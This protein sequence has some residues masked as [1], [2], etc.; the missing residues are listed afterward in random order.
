MFGTVRDM[1]RMRSTPKIR[2][3]P[4]PGTPTIMS[5]I[6]SSGMEPAGTPAAPIAVMIDIITNNEL[7]AQGEMHAENLGEEQDGHAFEEGGPVHVHGSAERHDEA[8]RTSST[9]VPRTTPISTRRPP[10]T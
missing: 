3:M 9:S 6:T 1:S 8:G 7:G 5:T 10:T 2:A 4:S